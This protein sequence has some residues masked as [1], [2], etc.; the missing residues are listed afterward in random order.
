MTRFDLGTADR[1]GG[2]HRLPAGSLL[3]V[4]LNR[5]LANY[6]RRV[7]GRYR[8]VKPDELDRIDS[9]ELYISPK[10]DGELWFLVADEGE[11]Y[12]TSPKGRIIVGDIPIL[13]EA[14]TKLLPRV[15]RTTIL[16]GEFFAIR[17]GGRPRVYDLAHAVAQQEVARLGF[18]AFDLLEGGDATGP[19]HP[20]DYAE[21]ITTI[22]RLTEGGK[23]LRA[24]KTHVTDRKELMPLYTEY[25]ESGKAEG[26]VVR[27][28][29]K[30]YK[31]KPVFH[32][33]AVIVGYTKRAEEPDQVRSLLL[34]VLRPD[35][36]YQLV[37]SVGN[38]GD[39]AQRAKLFSLL[40]PLVTDSSFRFAS[41]TG[42]LFRFVS[43]EHVAE[44][45][46]TDLENE[47]S[48]GRPITRMTLT[49]DAK[50]GW[51]GVQQLPGVSLIHPVLTR[52]REDKSPDEI[53][54]RAAQ[55][56]ER[57]Q[58]QDAERRAQKTR[59]PQSEVLRR[60]VYVKPTKGLL[61]IRKLLVWKTHK[62]TIS[63]DYPA[64]VVHFTDYSPGRKV[65][66]KRTVRL[67][68]D[69]ETAETLAEELLAANI[70]S[71]WERRD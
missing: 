9:G 65:P 18:F 46:V 51:S 43:P 20:E 31:V 30:T 62:D 14:R 38:M 42:A 68:P 25:V 58:L 11:V 45:Q 71:G 7:A 64:F 15:S 41:S 32:L 52:L 57:I 40:S 39:S 17:Q 36:V 60:E 23:R 27:N 34:A 55:L 61:A 3:D 35:G 29:S 54:V 16:A 48:S 19:E 2:G 49:F 5:R 59:L 22:Q 69:L 10:V 53:D 13:E 24:I 44:I 37:G 67:A 21:R 33:D 6:K 56:L 12:L 4:D 1:L 50:E 8:A 70:K 63:P 66:L 26:L 47:G 28:A